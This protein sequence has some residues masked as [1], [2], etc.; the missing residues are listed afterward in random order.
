MTKIGFFCSS[1]SEYRVVKETLKSFGNVTLLMNIECAKNA[2]N[3]NI[4]SFD[5][6]LNSLCFD[7]VNVWEY[8]S[9]KNVFF[10]L[11]KENIF[12]LASD[13]CKLVYKYKDINFVAITNDLEL[14]IN[15][16]EICGFHSNIYVAPVFDLDIGSS[17][18]WI[19]TNLHSV[20]I[21]PEHFLA[22]YSFTEV[23]QNLLVIAIERNV[24][25]YVSKVSEDF[26]EIFATLYS[27]IKVVPK[28]DVYDLKVPFDMNSLELNSKY[29]D[30]LEMDKIKYFSYRLALEKALKDRES[31]DIVQ[32]AIV[33]AGRGKIVDCAIQAGAKNIYVFENNHQRFQI[34]KKRKENEWPGFVQIFE[35]D[36]K[37]IKLQRNV[38]IIISDLLG[39]FADNKLLPECLDGYDKIVND[40]TIFIPQKL[41]SYVVPLMS[42]YI[43]SK[44]MHNKIV[45]KI[46]FTSLESTVFLSKPQLFMEYNYPGKNTNIQTKELD[47]EIKAN[48]QFS[49]FGGWFT[50][51][52]YDD[53]VLSTSP[54]E[55]T[56]NMN[57]LLQV[58]FQINFQNNVK[59]NDIMK[60]YFSRKTDGKT[61][62]YEWAVTKPSIVPI[63]NPGGTN[64]SIDIYK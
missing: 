21:S 9:I 3:D 35:G 27:L 53:V 4:G 57:S 17:S 49:G 45:K 31:N 16:Y 43:W 13:L 56:P 28:T 22:D 54:F 44:A 15:F 38:D 6:E 30:V 25:L 51:I 61:V 34:L 63:Q 29:Y 36:F 8:Y 18:L 59:S 39:E 62:W 37:K 64:F 10:H 60:A 11:R 23:F 55:H 2:I 50:A 32:V 26:K 33:G 19:T 40:N 12:Q 1:A 52:L 58:Y 20:F 42:Q 7:D 14:W 5:I 48:G 47:F 24:N 41:S 46:Y